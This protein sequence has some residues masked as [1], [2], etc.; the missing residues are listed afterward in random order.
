MTLGRGLQV[1]GLMT[2]LGMAKVAQ[3]T[4]MWIQAYDVG[5]ATVNAHA[6]ERDTIWLRAKVASLQSPASLVNVLGS[7]R[8]GLVAWSELPETDGAQLAQAKGN[9]SAGALSD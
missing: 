2:A 8:P 5:R 7:E 3:Q 6:A 1:V 4:T 9:G